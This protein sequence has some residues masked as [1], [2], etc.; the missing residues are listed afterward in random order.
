MLSIWDA[1]FIVIDVE[2][3][4]GNAISNRLT[5]IA[6]VT[7]SG[8]AAVDRFSSLIN[9]HQFIPVFIQQMTGISNE[10]AF[11]APEAGEVLPKVKEILL[12][13]DSVFVA[14]NIGFDYNFVKCAFEKENI[15]FPKVPKL[16][17]LKLSRR[18]LKKDI[19]KNVG[20][21][22]AYFGIKIKN[23]HRALGDADA[24]SGILC[25]LLELAEDEH[26][27]QSLE[28]LLEFQ[29]KQIKNFI[30]PTATQKRLQ[31]KIDILPHEPGVYYFSDKNG[32]VHY[33]GKAKN[34][35]DRVKSYFTPGNITSRKISAMLRKSYYLDWECTDSELAALIYESRKIKE[36]LPYYN[37]MEK[38]L[39]RFP[40]I[41]LT[42][43][44]EF[45]GIELAQAIEDDGSEYFGPFRSRHL[46][47][48]LME[49]ISRQFKVKNCENTIT[50]NE[51]HRPCFYYHIERCAAPCAALVS[52]DEYAHHVEKVR[53]YLSGYSEG[54]IKQ[55]EQRM[56]VLSENL[57]FEEASII[58]DQ[59]RDLRKLLDK[60]ANSPIS[61]NSDNFAMS[62]PISTKDKILQVLLIRCGKLEKQY[63]V[64]RKANLDYIISDI[65]SIYYSRKNIDISEYS[66]LD[67]N[68]LNI[69]NAWVF[70]NKDKA[71][72]V[73][74]NDISIDEAA[75]KLTYNIRNVR[76]GDEDPN[77]FI[78]HIENSYDI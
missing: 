45:P 35:K 6:C 13:K 7:T 73:Y 72:F 10:M 16:C 60:Q 41:K 42:A 55:M 78:D 26:G 77:E 46:A 76:F 12:C 63:T 50:P 33:V 2:T 67:I 70:R 5:D 15:E 61:V 58:R 18:L 48:M 32:A 19:K 43:G 62:F 20:S 49:N 69:I 29:N 40:F 23:R 21:L 34:L 1:N 44:D 47:E 54:I 22:A 51:A 31:E 14:H 27:I 66:R 24:T 36:L 3:T 28:E 59:I 65:K 25:E 53:L 56:E 4:G 64:G 37:T 52:K 17:T 39:R 74:F 11:A 9:P 8:G 75:E 30:P 71:D 57:E 68:D 38:K